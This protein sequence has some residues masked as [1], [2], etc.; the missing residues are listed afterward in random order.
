M[1]RFRDFFRHYFTPR[2]S[3]T[4]ILTRGSQRERGDCCHFGGGAIIDYRLLHCGLSNSNPGSCKDNGH[5]WSR[6]LGAQALL[7]C[8]GCPLSSRA[9]PNLTAAAPTAS[10]STHPRLTHFV[11]AKSIPLR[12]VFTLC[13]TYNTDCHFKVNLEVVFGRNGWRCPFPK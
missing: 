9:H 6:M 4:W 13:E 10:L 1:R 12:T 5:L 11:L 7:A 3:N 8:F 2:E